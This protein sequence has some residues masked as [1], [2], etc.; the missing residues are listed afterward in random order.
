MATL[1]IRQPA[2]PHWLKFH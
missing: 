1:L 2:I